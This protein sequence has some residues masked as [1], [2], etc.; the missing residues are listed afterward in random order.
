[1]SILVRDIVREPGMRGYTLMIMVDFYHIVSIAHVHVPPSVGIG[2]RVEV[3]PEGN[4]AVG[5]DLAISLPGSN[6]IIYCRKR[7]E[8]LTLL[9]KNLTSAIGALFKGGIVVLLKRFGGSFAEREE[10]TE[11]S[12]PQLR[13]D[14]CGNISNGALG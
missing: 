12:I 2:S 1:M 9:D 13:D 11:L 7:A 5:M 4:V 3:L 8:E 6:F 10:I 14:G